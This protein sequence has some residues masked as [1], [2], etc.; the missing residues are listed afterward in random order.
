LKTPKWFEPG[1]Y[2]AGVGA[3]ALAIVGFSVGG[4]VTSSTA[5]KMV[6]DQVRVE[7]TAAFVPI[8][9]ERSKRD[10]EFEATVAKMKSTTSYNRSDVVMAA[11]WAT[12]P[13]T[14]EPNRDVARACVDE[15]G[16]EF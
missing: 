8:C 14:D 16:V 5:Q 10:P 15:L 13:G 2:G 9:V 6:S 12:M 1:V 7:L 11:G 4:W 3:V